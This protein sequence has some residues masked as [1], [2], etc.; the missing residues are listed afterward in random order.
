MY[1]TCLL[2]TIQLEVDRRIGLR[3]FKGRCGYKKDC[4]FKHVAQV[5]RL[6]LRIL[7]KDRNER[8]TKARADFLEYAIMRLKG[9][10]LEVDQ[11]LVGDIEEL[12]GD[13]HGG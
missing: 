2:T 1:E 3:V 6:S 12:D 8:N 13:R 4:S 5:R 11:G 10:D 7:R 9:L